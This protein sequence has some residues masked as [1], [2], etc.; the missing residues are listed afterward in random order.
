MEDNAYDLAIVDP[1]YGIG[2]DGHHGVKAKKP[3]HKWK[4]YTFKHW[5]NNTPDTFY[6][7]ELE[8]V[9]KEQTRSDDGRYIVRY[10]M[11]FN[12]RMNLT[13]S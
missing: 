5:D 6:F 12:I 11:D 9:S 2:R 3:R 8:R 4:P 10:L 1:P 7:Y 13:A